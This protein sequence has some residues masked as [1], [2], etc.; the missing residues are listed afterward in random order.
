MVQRASVQDDVNSDDALAIDEALVR[1]FDS[2]PI[3]GD[4]RQSY[5]YPAQT[6]REEASIRRGGR[7]IAAKLVEESAGGISL[8]VPHDVKLTA[9]EQIDVGIYSG[10]YVARV[11]HVRP[12]ESGN[13]V[14]L[15]R[16]VA[17]SSDDGA[18]RSAR[19]GRDH[20]SGG[21]LAM[22]F[23]GAA[24]LLAGVGL[25][26]CVTDFFQGDGGRPATQP[27]TAYIHRPGG[28]QLEQV[29]E[30]VSILTK[31]EVAKKLQLT[32]EQQ[33]TFEGVLVGASN[34]LGAAYEESKN[35]PP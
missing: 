14:G 23:V 2:A 6:G 27:N 21:K 31:P 32:P 5:R 16:I 24:A 29:L 34:R 28:E 1:P 9:L 30:S 18:P 20:A 15:Q 19:R 22:L 3:Q 17:L 12:G 4:Q 25:S 26:T 11:I 7:T 33:T 13:R 10:W 8:E 35:A